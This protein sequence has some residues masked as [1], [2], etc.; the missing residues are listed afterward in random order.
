MP[1]DTTSSSTASSG[2]GRHAAPSKANRTWIVVIGVVVV[3]LAGAGVALALHAG[4]KNAAAPPSSN[5][6]APTTATVPTAICPLTGE[7]APGGS[8]P[9][10]PALA[11]K[12]DNYPTARP[13][14]GVDQADI[15]F[16]EP[17]EAQITRLVAVF[18]CQTPAIVGDVRSARAPDASIAD[19]LSDP[20]FVHAGGIGPI[21]ALVKA[22]NLVNFDLLED[23][24][25][26][27][28]PPERNAPYDTYVSPAAVWARDPSATTPPAPVFT[29]SPT[30]IG[31][32]PAAS[33]HIPFSSTN[34]ATWT[35]DTG[36][37]AW[38]LSYGGVPATVADGTPIGA[39]DVVVMT[40]KT[41][42]EP[43]LAEP[44]IYEVQAVLTGSGPVTVL[45]NG[46]QIS[47]T[48]S[49]PSMSDP[50]TLTSSTGTIIAL[51][52]GQSWVELVPSNVTVTVAP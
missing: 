22:A 48:W 26:V 28:N 30:P 7:P 32:T 5:T 50:M 15:V 6:T 44:G 25:L 36:K 17:V 24:S 12:V 23:G 39:S 35:W 2:R 46:Q 4:S 33:V 34:D 27:I 37:G 38:A 11:I 31:G 3:L 13:W 29:Y 45:R 42:A 19:L 47:G 10:R 14:S 40:V 18:Q 16:E 1:D 52:P 8:V 49:R 43:W 20:L 41:F 51:Q 9:A 21:L